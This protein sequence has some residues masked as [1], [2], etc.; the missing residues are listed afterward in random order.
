[1]GEVGMSNIVDRLRSSP[2]FDPD[3]RKPG[4]SVYQLCHAA[5]NEIEALKQFK[6]WAEP[7]CQDYAANRLEIDRL[8]ESLGQISRMRGNPDKAVVLITLT[9]AIQI[10]QQALYGGSGER[11]NGSLIDSGASLP[12]GA[13]PSPNPAAR[14][15][16]IYIPCMKHR[17]PI[18]ITTEWVTSP[19]AIP[20]VVCPECVNSSKGFCLICGVS[21]DGDVCRVCGDGSP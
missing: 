9:A 20:N 17:Q 18:F 6:E 16:T 10:A 4:D 5:A 11:T 13:K 12:D 2:A 21:Y 1:M 7:Q 19:L 15:E 3:N 14:P 8:R